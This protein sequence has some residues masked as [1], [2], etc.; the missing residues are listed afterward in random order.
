MWRKIL[1]CL[2]VAFLLTVGWAEPTD[3]DHDHSADHHKHLHHGKDEPHPHHE[4]EDEP[5][6]K[7]SPYNADFAFS[8]YEKLASLPDAKG[9]NI[10]FSPLS[11]SMALSMLA[12]GAKGETHS[13][14]FSTLGYS[15]LTAEQVNNGY[16]H[17]LHM[18]GHIQDS[19]LL[20]IG[21]A[22]AIQ[23]DFKPE[24]TFLKDIEHFYKGEAFS[25]DVSNPEVAVEEINK[26][27]AKKTKDMITDMVKSLDPATVMMIINYMYFKGKWE[28]AFKVEDTSK[29]DF[30]VDENTKV[31]VDMMNRAGLYDYF[32]DEGNFTTI[33]KVPYNGSASMIIVMPD[34][35]KMEEV[36][37]HICKDHLKYW[38]TNTHK[39]NLD[40]HMPKFS[41][42]TSSCLADTLKGMGMVDAFSDS[43]DLSGISTG[44]KLAVSKVLHKAVVSVDEEGTEA[45]AATGI[46]IVLMSAPIFV[47]VEVNR[48]FLFF[49]VEKNTRHILFM[50]KMNNPTA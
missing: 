47:K 1:C 31:S 10:F 41:L 36:E 17:L 24:D 32:H 40:L 19:L 16:E 22:L 7:L 3:H 37:K 30:H 49:I 14:I 4:G 27:I 29:G 34:Q 35:G 12:L 2:L 18:L 6:H 21:G 13:Q 39:T 20:E 43:A 28:D 42:S 8:L 5:C 33:I 45:A 15:S 46:G 50:G 44:A 26:F 38:R 48:P 25:V 11:V 23:K 9:K